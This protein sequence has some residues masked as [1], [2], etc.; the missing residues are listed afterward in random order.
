MTNLN[1]SNQPNENSGEDESLATKKYLI[2]KVVKAVNL[3]DA[4]RKEPEGL[5][6]SVQ[7]YEQI[8]DEDLE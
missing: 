6:V 1:R 8:F 5:T 4:L 2:T 3:A 7:I